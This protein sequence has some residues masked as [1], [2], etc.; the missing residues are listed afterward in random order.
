MNK[1][2]NI[3]RRSALHAQPPTRERGDCQPLPY[4]ASLII[5]AINQGRARTH[6]LGGRDG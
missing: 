1:Q 2:L 5:A 3:D 4:P 6:T